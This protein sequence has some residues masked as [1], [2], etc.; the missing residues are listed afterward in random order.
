MEYARYIK[1]IVNRKLFCIKKLFYLATSV[2]LQFFKSFI[3]PYFDYCLSIYIYFPKY[4]VQKISNCYNSCLFKLFKF[5]T[6]I[7][8]SECFNTFNNFLEKFNLF[9]FQ[10]RLFHR[11]LLFIHKIKFNDKSP[12]NLKNQIKF[13]LNKDM[14]GGQILRNANDRYVAPTNTHYGQNTFSYFV[15]ELIYLLNEKLCINFNNFNYFDENYNLFKK[16]SFNNINLI[17]L[18]II[19]AF[20]KFNLTMKNFDYI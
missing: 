4:T 9:N 10:H 20:S 13:I 6:Q 5:K 3:L 7:K 8:T 19:E 17:F 14:K 1:T 2:K 16:R 15:N 11:L 12:T 18:V